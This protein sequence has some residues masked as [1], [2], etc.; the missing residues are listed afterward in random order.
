MMDEEQPATFGFHHPREFAARRLDIGVF[1]SKLGRDAI[2]AAGTS[3][4]AVRS[5][6]K[7]ERPGQEGAGRD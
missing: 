4:E 2:K 6:L 7:R 5:H 1:D 3:V